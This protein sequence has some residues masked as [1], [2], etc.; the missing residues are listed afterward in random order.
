[1]KCDNCGKN[2][3][4]HLTEIKGGKKGKMISRVA[5][6]S[7]TPDFWSA[8]DGLADQRYWQNYGLT[9]DGKGEPQQINSMSHGCPPSR[10]RQMNVLLTD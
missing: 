5:Y 1:M 7:R 3:T 10:F 6:Q 4:V 8:L 9:G 2:A